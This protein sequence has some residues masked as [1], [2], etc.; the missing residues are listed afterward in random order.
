M[1]NDRSNAFEGLTLSGTGVTASRAEVRIR[2][3]QTPEDA[4]RELLQAALPSGETLPATKSIELYHV[5]CL[6]QGETNGETIYG[7][8]FVPEFLYVL[9]LG[10]EALAGVSIGSPRVLQGDPFF[11]NFENAQLRSISSRDPNSLIFPNVAGQL[12]IHVVDGADPD[13]VKNALAQYVVSVEGSGPTYTAQC[14]P[15]KEGSIAKA[16]R[17]DVELVEWVEPVGILRIIDLI[18]GWHVDRVI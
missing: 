16:I 7:V 17:S 11:P 4:C 2:N 10:M 12:I 14:F 13:Q 9:D 15:F 6:V 1:R 18:P 3:K 8:Y 5:R